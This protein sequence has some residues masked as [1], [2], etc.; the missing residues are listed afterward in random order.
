[1]KDEGLITE[2]NRL[3]QAAK[4]IDEFEFVSTLISYNG[5]GDPRL[6]THLYESRN[7]VAD[8]KGQMFA[9]A[10]KNSKTR[11]G[12]LLYCHIFEMDEL[13]NVIGNLLRIALG[14]G[15]RFIPDLYNKH[16]NQELTPTDK[17]DRLKELATECRFD[18]LILGLQELYSSRIRNAFFHSSY[19]L[20][21]DNFCIVKGD[22]VKIENVIYNTLSIDKYLLPKINSS[23]GFIERFF[24]LIDENKRSYKENKVIEGNFPD[25][26]KIVVLGHPT[27][28]LI[29]FQ[30]MNG[31]GIA[32]R[33]LHGMENFAYAMNIR[34]SQ[35]SKEVVE[36]REKLSPYYDK[37]KPEGREFEQVKGEVLKS[38]NKNLLR[39]LAI[40][41]YNWANN[42]TNAAKGKDGREMRFLLET[43][44]NR[45]DESIRIDSTFSKAYHNKATGILKLAKFNNNLDNKIRLQAIDLL[46][47]C[48]KHEQYMLEAHI[49]Y[50][51]LLYEMTSEETESSKKITGFK[52]AVKKFTE[53]IDIFQ[54]DSEIWRLRADAYW[55]LAKLDTSNETEYFNLSVADYTKAISI[56]PEFD[57]FL[58]LASLLGTF[59]EVDKE[60][61][62]ALYQ[63]S[64]SILTDAEKRYGGHTDIYYRMGNK[65]MMLA[66]S[67]GNAD[68]YKEAERCFGESVELDKQNVKA[69]NNWGN[70]LLNTALQE[71]ESSV[72]IATLERGIE[73]LTMAIKCN[74]DHAS[75]YYNLG[76]VLCEIWRRKE[77]EQK[78][79]YLDKAS[80][81][82][83]KGEILQPGLCDIHVSRVF[84]LKDDKKQSMYWLEKFLSAN[85]VK[86][87]YITKEKDFKNLLTAQGFEEFLTKYCKS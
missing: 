58:S 81:N 40:I 23:I 59:A 12:L 67:T 9:K 19:S 2:L 30:T 3:F 8:I 70:C 61:S 20:V 11:L 64:I 31:S 74:P 15:F 49:N 62:E 27:S 71:K 36:L 69:W 73:K 77:S 33:D 29:G 83:L 32:A 84:A 79:G 87:E 35:D 54:K 75:A 45:Y 17:I 24:S 7:L 76:N 65:Y 4:K 63:K 18:D 37:I 42:T 56:K 51:R 80:E 14:Q 53:A 22:G 25:K 55:W 44:I 57:Y 82:L 50:G 48:L 72:A 21:D 13:F 85:V 26:Q 41:Y 38:G 52:A 68:Y 5:M 60:H 43:A 6:L 34:F 46:N 39:N 86:K 47:D 66:Q 16:G 10:D 1:M 78:V 28:G